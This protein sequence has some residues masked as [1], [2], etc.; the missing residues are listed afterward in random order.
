MAEL[1]ECPLDPGGYFITKGTEKVILIQ[2]QLSKNRI[3]V[4]IGRKGTPEASVT[5]STHERRSKTYVAKEKDHV[6]LRHNNFSEDIPVVIALKAMGLTSDKE[7]TS[8]ICSDDAAYMDS[9]SPSIDIAVQHKIF[10]QQQALEW[11]GSRNKSY[12]K[13]G[14]VKNPPEEAKETLATV[15]VA[16]I[17]VIDDN[18]RPKCMYL[19]MMA[20]RVIMA[21]HDPIAM[22]DRDY[23]GNKRL[24][25]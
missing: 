12:R 25:L 5:S 15:V 2:E 21:C 19:C 16:H 17:P 20:R 10:T 6:V 11:I 23:V 18:F 13:P 24:E 9:F 22:D 4:D 8:L 1:G 7:I 3:I 14:Q